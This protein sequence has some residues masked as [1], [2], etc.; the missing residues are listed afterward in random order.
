[1]NELVKKMGISPEV[2]EF[3]ESRQE[4]LA[5]RFA[6]IDKK[7]ELCQW[8]VLEAFQHFGIAERHFETT[9]GYGYTDEGRDRLEEVYARIFGGED[10]LVRPQIISGTHALTITLAGVLR[11][12]DEVLFAVGMPYDTLQGVV[13]LREETGALTE[14]GITPK[15]AELDEAGHPDLERI[16]SMINEKTRMVEIQ[17]SRGYDFRPSLSPEEIGRIIEVVRRVKP[18]TVVMVDNCYGEFTRDIE[19][20]DVGAD[21]TVGSLIKNPGGGLAPIGGYVVGRKDLVELVAARLTAP[22]IG[23]EAGATLGVLRS[24]YQGLFFAPTVTASAIKTAVFAAKIFED[25]GFT[26]SPAS[27]EPRQ[28]IV[29][30]VECKTPEGLCAF[31]LGI[32][33]AAPVDSYV[34]PE[35]WDMPGYDSPVIMAAGSFMSGASIELSADG[36][37]K[38]PYT[39]YFQGGLTWAHGKLGIMRAVE[40]MRKQG[41]I[42]L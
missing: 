39:A 17:R 16:A 42:K 18:D 9:T 19:P 29:Q 31:C 35:P 8:K 37:M 21:L 32:Q 24:F 25:L 30:A 12:G 34:T 4:M 2:F 10:A 20:G 5:E 40:E 36:P 1:M 14:F 27:T 41:L 26:V 6:E 3:C 33:K 38:A 13:G 23:K 22:G 11:P 15:V 7:A 28:D